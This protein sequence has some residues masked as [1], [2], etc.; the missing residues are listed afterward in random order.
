MDVK[1]AFLNGKLHEV[2]YVNQLE[3]FIDQD[4]P[5]HVYML[6]KA[7]YDLKQAP[8][9]SK[10]IDVRYHFIKEHVENEVVEL[11]FVRMEYQLVDIFT[12][13]LPRERSNFLIENIGMKSMSPETLKNMAEEEEE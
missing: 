13:A 4:K 7:L 8:C 3:G 6:K 1:T 5:N 10:H 9:M 12:K 2:V 11:Y